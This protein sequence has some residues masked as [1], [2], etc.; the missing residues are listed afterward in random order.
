[1]STT[2]PRSTP[3]AVEPSLGRSSP[4]PA[5]AGVS[6]CLLLAV[7]QI[8]IGGYQL[9]YGNQAIQIAF[10]KHW[11]HPWMYGADPMVRETLAEYPSYF[12][13]ALAPL[14]AYTNVET[15]YLV[16]QILT[17]FATL[18]AV[19]WLARSIF[20][21][22]TTA[23]AAAV[24]VALAGNLQAL[25]GDGLYSRGFT[26]TFAALPMAVAALALA[27]R[28]RWVLAFALAGVLFNIHALTAAYTALMLGA[29][30]LAD[31]REQRLVMWVGRAGLAGAV[32]LGF[33][34]PTLA[35]MA[36]Q[37]QSFD[38]EWINLT[39][40]RSADHSFP[41]TWWATGETDVPRFLM[42]FALFVLAWSFPPLRRGEETGGISGRGSWGGARRG[43]RI[44]VLMSLAVA[45]LFAV[46]Y[47]FSEIVPLPFII[48]LQPFRASRLLLVLMVVHIVHGAVAAI[49][50]GLVRRP[51]G[52]MPVEEDG[53][54]WARPVY[55]RVADVAAGGLI[56]ATLAVPGMLALLPL[57][58][59]CATAAALLAGHL[60]WRQ[61]LVA[62]A[63][64]QVVVLAW[65]QIDFPLAFWRGDFLGGG[66]A[67]PAGMHFLSIA[68][69]LL[70]GVAAALLALARDWRVHAAVAGLALLTGAWFAAGLFR[71]ESQED[72]ASEH[73]QLA[74][75][76]EWAR[77][78]TPPD[79]VFLTAQP[80]FR[81]AAERAIVGTWRDGTQLYFSAAY[82]AEWLDRAMSVEPGLELTDDGA[83]LKTHGTGLDALDDQA[84]VDLADQYKASYIVL[85]TP[86]Q[87]RKLTVAFA[88]AAYTVYEPAIET[89]PVQV[90]PGVFDPQMWAE[91]EEFMN[92]T[93][94]QNIAQYRMADLTLQVVDT[95]GRPVQ[96]LPL[97]LDQ[98]RSAF[99]FGVSLGF[100]EPNGISPNGDQK[101]PT[102]RPVELEKAPEIFDGS[103]IAFSSKWQYLEPTKGKYNWSDLDKYVDY[104]T[105][106]GWTMEF[107]HLSG[108]LPNWV[109]QMGGVD[110]QTGLNFPAPV[111]AMQ[112]EF[113]RH[114]LDTVARYADRIK[115]WQ[116]VNEKYMMQYVPPV[117]KML[118]QKYPRNQFGL[119]DCV[120]FYD[121]SAG[122]NARPAGGLMGVGRGGGRNANQYKG[123]DAVDWLI[124]KGIHP[125]FFS[126]HGHYPLGLWADPRE[127]YNVFDYFAERKVKVHISEEYLQLGGPIYGPMRTGTWTPELQGE[128]LARFFTICFSHRDVDMANLWGLA[129]NGWGASN[130]GLIDADNHARPAWEVLKR[131]ITQ[132]WRTHVAS[133]LSLDGR[134]VEHVYHG[135]YVATLT[136]ADGRTV[137]A[138]FEVPEKAAA[139]IQLRLDAGRGILEIAK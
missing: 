131:L 70:A 104:G 111:P 42:I 93:V 61:A 121:Q 50:S 13:R 133:E 105:K 97:K 112:A 126:V 113:N 71:Q 36:G 23:L 99:T 79:A 91:S 82:G 57:T 22:H 60:S 41:S 72:P 81:A 76:A 37:H 114:C 107:H 11:A 14:L 32:F 100:F 33:A 24:V 96:N 67:G 88:G 101:P 8:A 135:T 30:M 86:A 120:K 128:Y 74:D 95:D 75:V 34:A 63:V 40:V 20:R 16:L 49:R 48:R 109:E 137:A 21:A 66:A 19:Y 118:Q 4:V 6:L 12:F 132:T 52:N 106:N 127:M 92:T 80:N 26:H 55:G 64:L 102:V 78:R 89:P 134:V 85:R 54:E 7:A 39:R 84:L 28:G 65:L 27:F 119:S 31:I 44:I 5:W 110:G 59:L 53:E 123:A 138:S 116:V 90:P 139:A 47:V 129:P 68:V 29:G 103:M 38:G 130:S 87:P 9:G 46:G 73:A 83:R 122:M 115:Y 69:L 56:L 2:T 136:L 77:G 43:T 15:L 51:E 124:S 18:A 10:L 94:Q 125:D 62:G 108:I 117:F 35:L 58:L 98:K 45:G 1:M 17:S 3:P 25:A